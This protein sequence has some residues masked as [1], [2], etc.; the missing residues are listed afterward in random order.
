MDDSNRKRAWN[1][2]WPLGTNLAIAANMVNNMLFTAP[3][4]L[5]YGHDIPRW[6]PRKGGLYI[7]K[8]GYFI[9]LEEGVRDFPIKK[10]WIKGVTPKVTHFLW[11]VF[12]K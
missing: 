7:V 8:F 9:L 4:P 2:P 12:I 6:K 10:V 3:L 1:I 11:L 5:E